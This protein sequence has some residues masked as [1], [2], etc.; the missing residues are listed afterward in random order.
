[1]DRLGDSETSGPGDFEWE[2]NEESADPPTGSR[3]NASRKTNVNVLTI[4]LLTLREIDRFK[5]FFFFFFDSRI[6]FATF[7]SIEPINY[8]KIVCRVLA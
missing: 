6:V 5:R 8:R 7:P 3:D 2:T 1:M 4:T